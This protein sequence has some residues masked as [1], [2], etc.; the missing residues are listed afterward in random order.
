MA[1]ARVDQAVVEISVL[2]QPNARVD[3]AVVEI[4]VAPPPVPP[5]QPGQAVAPVGG[6]AAAREHS[7]GGCA[8]K[9][10]HYDWCLEW[11]AFFLRQVKFPPPCS[12]PAEYLGLD[13]WDEDR[14]AIPP[15]ATPFRRTAG[16]VTPTTASGDNVVLS[17]RVPYGSDGI[18][19]GFFTS[20]SGAGFAQGSG[21]I[22]WRFRRN[23]WYLKDLSNFSFLLGDPTQ[24]VPLTQGQILTS[25]QLIQAIVNI[26]NLSGLIQI[27]NSTVSAGLFGFWWPR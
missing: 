10:T 19:T 18:L 27:G 3:Q 8:P 26:P 22:V 2:Q 21:D 12:I 6:P 24:P 17:F 14:G 9:I 15:L 16:I 25:G 11:E 5:P 7:K 1:N 20:Y 13:P 4:C 23:Q